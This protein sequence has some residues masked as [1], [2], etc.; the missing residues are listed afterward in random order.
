M[1]KVSKLEAYITIQHIEL[2]NIVIMITGS[3][4][5]VAY[6]TEF[7][8]LGILVLSMSSTCF[9]EQS[10]WAL[11][12]GVFNDVTSMFQPCIFVIIVTSFI[13]IITFIMDDVFT[14][15]C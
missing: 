3:I 13:G 12:V 9:L 14:N 10:Y 15:V 1:R 11:L 2:M 7:L 5:G 4:V 6:I 8:S